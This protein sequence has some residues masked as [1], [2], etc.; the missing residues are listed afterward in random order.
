VQRLREIAPGV[1]VAT[2][3]RSTTNSTVVVADDGGCLVIDP[4]LT[5][6]DVAGLAADL[7]DGG[8]RPRLGSPTSR[9]RSRTCSPPIRSAI[10]CSG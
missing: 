7:S 4:A 1:L 2:A 8:L 3:E 10:T 9:F 6:A 5:A